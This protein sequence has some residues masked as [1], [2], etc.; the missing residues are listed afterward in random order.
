MNE[1]TQRGNSDPM[2]GIPYL[3]TPTLSPD[4]KYVA[5]VYA[6]DI[7]QVPI[8]GGSAERLTVHSAGNDRPHY[9][10]DGNLLAFTSF[11]T[12]NG[13]IYV[14]PMNGG[15]IRRLTYHYSYCSVDDWSHDGKRII[16]TSARD[17]IGYAIYWV[18]L[19]ATTP[20][21]VCVEPEKELQHVQVSPDGSSL[22]FNTINNAWW[23]LGPDKFA[24]SHMWVMPLGADTE[25]IPRMQEGETPVEHLS[26]LPVFPLSPIS[27]VGVGRW[28]LWAQ[29]GQGL[30]FV[31]DEQGVENI[32]YLPL[33]EGGEPRQITHF[34]EGRLLW[35][36]IARNAKELVFEH[37]WSLW[38]L[39]LES[40][41]TEPI[42][43]R[44]RA[45]TKMT[46]VRT[47][48]WSRN[49]SE[50]EL[51]PDGKKVAFVAR[52]EV[53][54]DFAD[55]ET[56]KDLRRGT[57]FRV[58]N[59]TARESQIT[60]T[61]DSKRLIY[62]SDRYGELDLFGY[63][64][65]TR[66]ET[67]LT[68]D[69]APKLLPCCSPDGNWVAYIR[70]FDSVYLLSLKTGETRLFAAGNFVRSRSLAWSPDSRWIA[71]ISHDERFFSN[72]YVKQLDGDEEPRQITFLSNII[73]EGLLW[74]QDGRF[75]IFTSA[76]YRMEAQI[77]R[78]DLCLPKPFLR[79]SE[80]EK[81][82]KDKDKDEK[83]GQSPGDKKEDTETEGDEKQSQ[84]VSVD[85]NAAEV[86]KENDTQENPHTEADNAGDAESK[87]ES[88]EEKAN[89]SDEPEKIKPIE[90][91]FEGIERRLYFLTPIQM[92][93]EAL[94]I[95]HNSNDLLFLAQVAGKVNIWSLPLD[96][97]RRDQSPKQL[98]ANSSSIHSVQFAPDDKSYYFVE[99]GQ[100]SIRK[101]P[102]SRETMV[103]STYGEVTVDFDQEK[104]QVFQ[105]AWR[106]LRDTFYDPTFRGLDWNAIRD[107]F[108]PLA[109]GVQTPGE[110]RSVLNLMVGELRTSHLGA[111]WASGGRSNDGYIGV[112]FD[113][114]EYM[115]RGVW[116]VA[117]IVPDSPAALQSQPPMIGE[118]LVALD[119]TPV[120]PK[121]NIDL[122]LQRTVGRR[123]VVQLS[124]SIDG[125]NARELAIR[126]I[127]GG[128]YEDLL[129]HAWVSQNEA[130]VHRV[131]NG[132]LG[133]VHV[134]E[135][136]YQAYQ[137]FLVNLDVETYQ[138]DGVVL[139]I[140]YN[141][142][143][144]IAT[145]ILDV[146]T[147]RSVLLTGFRGR[148]STDAYHHSGNRSLNK[149]TVLVT[150][151]SSASNAE[152]F[153]EI[154]RRLGLGKVVGK[155]TAG[156]VIGT[157]GVKLLN[158]LW[159]R[160]PF[161]SISTPEG[162]NLEG[163]GRHVDVEVDQMLGDWTKGVDR[164][165]DVAVETLL[166]ELG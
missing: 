129:Y 145:F 94:S 144:H 137:E 68:D 164:Q 17:C 136:S 123:V 47:E 52:G 156:A 73:G 2:D 86:P 38:R 69:M 43:I 13:D 35:P 91:V 108:A 93:A 25:N 131:S 84:R 66:S 49:F 15:E 115:K 165:L 151:E 124:S 11:R 9:S 90:I 158:K 99:D 103:L 140:R 23:R 67:R 70:G 53:F 92:D 128:K 106:W 150:N 132:R 125:E 12:G 149:P 60:W 157:I 101:F 130:Y 8:E 51:S 88:D 95:S 122:L 30:Y 139:D 21:L 87:G 153:T 127:N 72:V 112:L 118:Y 134:P 36:S 64:F 58:T 100:I 78:V 22:A 152:I 37:E 32:F 133:Y 1:E 141:G 33:V 102:S 163:T 154:Y 71:Y 135:M 46:S 117:S 142:G 18:S 44:V 166:H 26:P 110:L 159:F 81:L 39:D 107:R 16:F 146:L 65:T 27:P 98:T 5:F 45:D 48:I 6:S 42:N 83:N 76:Q 162:E 19:E 55:K 155:P 80:F 119:G 85:V 143:G 82:F 31:S 63:D 116:R 56:E 160:L 54:A 10:P 50:M 111:Y 105:E 29:D 89:E 75:L 57:A 28:P 147:R 97:P 40:E 62:T 79:E 113:P 161:I 59:T 114:A 34:Q 7:W 138:K 126:P 120:T 4:G 61:P 3:R 74:S 77:V 109:A 20:Q 41:E 148:L 96:E 14:L 121:T 24:P 104:I